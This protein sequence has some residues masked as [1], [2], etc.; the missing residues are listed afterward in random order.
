MIQL[1]FFSMIGMLIFPRYYLVNNSTATPDKYV[2]LNDDDSTNMTDT[3]VY[4]KNKVFAS[5]KES[6]F[7]M[8]ILLTASNNPD[9]IRACLFYDI[10]NIL[11]FWCLSLFI[12]LV[13]IQAYSQNR[14]ASIYFM[15][16]LIIGMS[17]LKS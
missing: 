1:Y 14:L 10:L 9:G 16:F 7:N 4:V 11:Y 17:I 5:I 13:T 2:L 15:S 12:V 3:K 8:L 6:L